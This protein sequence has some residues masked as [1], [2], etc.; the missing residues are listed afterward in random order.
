[1][2]L[3]Q[4]SAQRV[5]EGKCKI[6]LLGAATTYVVCIFGSSEDRKHIEVIKTNFTE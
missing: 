2:L 1:M 6:L 5:N 4:A 3:R